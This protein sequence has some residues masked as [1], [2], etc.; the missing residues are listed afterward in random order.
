[1]YDTIFYKPEDDPM[2]SKHAAVL[3]VALFN[4]ATLCCVRRREHN[5]LLQEVHIFTTVPLKVK[6]TL[7]VVI[8]RLKNWS[9]INKTQKIKAKRL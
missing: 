3:I 2:E 4:F 9:E 1:V 7:S 5:K 8:K 6:L